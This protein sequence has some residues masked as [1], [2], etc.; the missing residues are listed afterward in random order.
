[1]AD[2]RRCRT[3]TRRSDGYSLFHRRNFLATPSEDRTFRFQIQVYGPIILPLFI[4]QIDTRQVWNDRTAER[5]E[6]PHRHS[7]VWRR[8]VFRVPFVDTA[9]IANID[10]E[11]HIVVGQDRKPLGRVSIAALR[12]RQFDPEIGRASCRERV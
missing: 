5:T 10:L 2:S 1:M 3:G 4:G 12:L 9:F 11:R 7:G 6:H 8:L